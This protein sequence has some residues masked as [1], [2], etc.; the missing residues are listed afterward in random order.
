MTSASLDLNTETRR[1]EAAGQRLQVFLAHAGIASRRAAEK[2][3]TEGR[4]SV[5]NRIVSEL[6]SRVFPGDAV[7]LDGKKVQKESIS[8]YL[9]LNKPPGYLCSSADPQG[10]PL[11]LELL[12]NENNQRLYSVGRL[13]F[14]SCGLIFFTNDGDFAAKL[15]HPGSGLE[16]EYFVEATGHISDEVISAFNQGICIEDVFYRAKAVHRV[17]SRCIKIILIEGK[18][19]EIRKIFSHFR[20][21]PSLL[22]RI[23]IGPV[24]LGKLAEGESRALTLYELKELKEKLY[25]NCN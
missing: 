9:I 1:E 15:G 23:R 25:G 6:G 17:G 4:V 22:R 14:M 18:N 13:D 19:R 2:I 20:L 11:A 21:H 16:K 8:A 5:N 7:L 24:Q 3:I 12:P 10:R